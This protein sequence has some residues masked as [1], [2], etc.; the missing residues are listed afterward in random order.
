[1]CFRFLQHLCGVADFALAGEEHQHVA[2]RL[3]FQLSDRVDDRLGLVPHFGADD[4]V[5]RVVRVVT[6]LICRCRDFQRPV[7]DFDRVDPSGHLDDRRATAG[8]MF[9]TA[10]VGG[11]P[12]GLDGR[13]RDDHLE[14]GPAGQELTQIPE[15][16]VDVEAALVGLV[17][18]QGVVA[19][20]ASVALDLGEQDAVGHQ[21][22]QRAVA[23]LVG[24]AHRV[25]D[26]V[27]ERGGQFVGDALGDGAGGEPARL[28]VPDGAADAAAQLQAD[29]RQ[30]GGLARTCLAGDDDDLVLG[31]G[32]RDLVTP[33]ADRQ[34]GVGDRGDGGLAG[35][36]ER[37]G[38]GELFGDL[39]ELARGW[40]CHADS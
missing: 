3:L 25:A 28:G 24:E 39:L 29:L 26:G 32:P 40:P 1:M 2:G 21:L 30:L 19:Q 35:R 13:R 27:A 31:D 11:E 15:Q 22:D 7:P 17:E 9:G 5:V 38:G 8:S 6:V 37:L 23:G 14:V 34:V 4:L 12:F 36:D 10:E 16:E 18:D 33:V 20:Q